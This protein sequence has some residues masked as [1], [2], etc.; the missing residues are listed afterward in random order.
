MAQVLV[1]MSGGVD[2]SVA[3]AMLLELGHDVTGVHLKLAD[4]AIEDQVPGHGCCT[5][6]D[7]QDARRAAQVLGIPY[8]VWDLSELFR[9][10]VQ[11]P[12]AQA[13]AA[14]ITPN[15]CVT[16]NERVKY[17]GLLDKA[18]ALGFDALATGHHARLRR[19][20]EVVTAPG[21]DT[22]LQ[23][24]ADR[25]KDQSYVL[26]VATQD[27]LDRTLLPVGEIA[28]DEVRRRAQAFGLRVATKP[29]SYD[30]C[31]IPDGDTAGYLAGHLPPSP[32]EIVDLDGRPLGR[33]DGCG[34]TRSASDAA[35]TS[36]HTSG[37]SWSTSTPA[38]R[39]CGSGRARRWPAGGPRSPPRPGRP[40]RCPSVTC[41][42]RSAPTAR[43][44][45][46]ASSRRT[47]ACASTSTSRCTAS[48]SARR[49]WSTTPPTRCVS[50]A[51][52]S[53]A[54]TAPPASRS[55]DRQADTARWTAS[56]CSA[57]AAKVKA[58]NS[59]W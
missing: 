28:K 42:S 6:D 47:T 49:P 25:H 35:S 3:A 34:A 39:P 51:A 58:W 27:Q 16:C 19:H 54:P 56:Q 50:A 15:P 10:E 45:P 20:G 37:G 30:V 21:P 14:G 2:S 13:Y 53:P 23:R 11:D 7:A 1:A 4:L 17:A 18:R 44:S 33:H 12:F 59:S 8:Y 31:F 38:P 32:G 55:S 46:A 40:G 5:L 24:A 36:A 29:D 57:M 41:A 9:R 26:Y 48:R 52:A 43:P 22:R